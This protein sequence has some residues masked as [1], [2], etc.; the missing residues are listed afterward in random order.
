MLFANERKH[1]LAIPAKTNDGKKPT[2]AWLI[3]YIVENLMQ[4]TRKEL[5]I[6]DDHV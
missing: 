4:D 5:F 6:L 3:Q 1:T 2:I